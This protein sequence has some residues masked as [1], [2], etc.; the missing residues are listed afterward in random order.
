MMGEA[1]GQSFD[2]GRHGGGGRHGG[3]SK[4]FATFAPADDGVV[5]GHDGETLAVVG[6]AFAVLV[7]DEVLQPPVDF[8]RR[9]AELVVVA[10]P[11]YE[12]EGVVGQVFAQGLAQVVPP[13]C[14]VVVDVAAAQ[15]G[16]EVFVAVG[17]GVDA[18]IFKGKVAFTVVGDG[19][20]RGR[21]V[22]HL[23]A[24]VGLSYR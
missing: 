3:V 10:C 20:G 8:G 19:H 18:S 23:K 9:E 2:E 5:V 17:R 13:E 24:D 14:P 22:A 16:H 7:D 4:L 21:N 15:D 11:V 6:C 12:R 1:A